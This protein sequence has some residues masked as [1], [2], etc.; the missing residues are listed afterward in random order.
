VF[1]NMSVARKRDDRALAA[2][3]LR[4]R[5]ALLR[6]RRS[7]AP[8]AQVP[9]SSA[10]LLGWWASRAG[11]DARAD[12]M[13]VRRAEAAGD[14]ARARRRAGLLLLDEPAAGSIRRERARSTS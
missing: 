14:R 3:A 7:R 8:S 9:R 5:L 11:P 10:A 2:R 4:P 13:P 1:F 12:A 6:F